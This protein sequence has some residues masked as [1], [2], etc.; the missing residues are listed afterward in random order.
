MKKYVVP[1]KFSYNFKKYIFVLS[2]A[3]AESINFEKSRKTFLQF[4]LPY[5]KNWV[6]HIE[7]LSQH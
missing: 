2:N 5:K 4:D 3:T 1:I 6:K 7:N